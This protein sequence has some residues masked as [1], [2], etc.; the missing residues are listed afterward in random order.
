M[1]TKK[2]EVLLK[3]DMLCNIFHHFKYYLRLVASQSEQRYKKLGIKL[4]SRR[5]CV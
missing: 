2:W 1:H 5:M 4:V 3:S